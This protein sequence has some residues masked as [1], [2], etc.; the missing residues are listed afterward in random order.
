MGAVAKLKVSIH[1]NE[2]SNNLV[3]FFMQ[4][5]N[6]ARG[7]KIVGIAGIVVDSSDVTRRFC[8]GDCAESPPDTVFDLLQL[9]N[10]LSS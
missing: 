4:C 3:D 1:E 5:A 10:R 2:A 8:M 6:E 7:G 9:V